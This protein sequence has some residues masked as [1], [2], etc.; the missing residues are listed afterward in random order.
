MAGAQVPDPNTA[1]NDDQ[2]CV[3]LDLMWHTCAVR[4]ARFVFLDTIAHE[5][6]ILHAKAKDYPRLD[7]F[8][9]QSWVNRHQVGATDF[10]PNPAGHEHI[11]ETVFL[12][13]RTVLLKF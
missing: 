4:Q 12:Q 9:S 8:L 11:A 10:H 7:V 3:G 1:I 2:L 5:K 6:A 13:L